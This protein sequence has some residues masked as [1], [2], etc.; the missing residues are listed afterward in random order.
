MGTN[1]APSKKPRKVSR[2]NDASKSVAAGTS[3]H[4]SDHKGGAASP[5]KAHRSAKIKREAASA[6][7]PTAAQRK[8][9]TKEKF[10]HG[11]KIALV[12]VGVAA[13][14][15]SVTAMAC[16]GVLNQAAN[17]T[18]YALTG[19]VAGT[20]NGVNIKEDTITK[21][22]MSTRESLG[23]TEDAAWAKYL[24]D[25]GLTPESYR[26]NL[27][28][29]YAS[30][31]LLTAAEKE[32]NV[33]VT[34]E[35]VDKAWDDAVAS[36]GGDEKAFLEL[37]GQMGFDEASYKESLKSQLAQQKLKEAV[38]PA[39]DPSDE[40]II[41]YLNENLGTYND[42]RRSSHILIKVDADASEEDAAKAQARAQE[43]LDKV[44]SGELSF[45]DA[46]KEYS[47]DT[48]KDDGGDVGWD[49]LTTFVTE[50]QDALNG[51]AKDQVS[52][53]VKSTYGWHIIKCTDLFHVDG[54]VTSLDQVPKDIVEKVTSTIKNTQASSDYSAWL[55]DYTEKADIQI[56]PMPENVPYN[57]DMKLAEQA[58]TDGARGSAD[59]GSA[60]ADAGSG[61][62]E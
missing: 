6:A 33:T 47:E 59:A 1:N 62:A 42:A 29:S 20:V 22:V 46:A 4:R 3:E 7:A 2:T 11:A 15:L 61:S 35:D 36:Y 40:D 21:Q 30:Q 14:L 41:A 48:S 31:Y 57:V 18:D 13:M 53:L 50:Y 5:T 58:A 9:R 55:A 51:L 54:E 19:G 16:S 28:R 52:V 26:E 27:I 32:Y 56:N 17:T 43:A 34:S 60:G 44:N 23:Y 38:A 49:K 39:K 37:M 12:G 8:Q 25:Q 45:E 10:S 24:S